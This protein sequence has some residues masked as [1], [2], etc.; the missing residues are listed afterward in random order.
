MQQV[1]RGRSIRSQNR[2]SY[3]KSQ[4]FMSTKPS[5]PYKSMTTIKR[6]RGRPRRQPN[7]SVVIPSFNGPQPEELESDPSAESESDEIMDD[8]KPQY[9]MVAASGLG[10]TDTE[11]VT[12]RD[13]SVELVPSFVNLTSDDDDD[14]SSPR[15]HKRAKTLSE[16][17]PDPIADDSTALL[18]Q[19]QARVYGP[20]DSTK[21]SIIP[22]RSKSSPTLDDSATSAA[23]LRQ[24][25]A[26]T[27]HSSLD[28]SS[29]DSLMGPTQR[30][31]KPLPIRY[32]SPKPLPGGAPVPENPPPRDKPATIPASYLT[33][34]TTVS[35]IQRQAAK[36]TP[37]EQTSPF[38]HIQRKVSL[39]PHFPPS[40]SFNHKYSHG[41]AESRPQ[42][43]IKPTPSQPT[44]SGFSQSSRIIPSS[45]KKRKLSPEPRS[46]PTQSSQTSSRT[47]IGFAGLARAKDITDD[48]APKAPIANPA[49]TKASHSPT[50]QLLGA[51][52]S[53]S[54]D[55]L[56]RV[57]SSDSIISEV[58]VVRR[59]PIT[60]TDPATT[61]EAR[62]QESED[63]GSGDESDDS[64]DGKTYVSKTAVP[65]QS[66]ASPEKVS[67]SADA[68]SQAFEIGHEDDSAS[69][70]DSESDSSEVMIVRRS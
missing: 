33:N 24:F 60:S 13:Q 17:S 68:L 58:I 2:G 20:D 44:N 5:V 47:K 27:R 12:S 16:T 14:E 29:S 70:S 56:A 31:L 6:P 26:H 46:V 11:D 34:N 4:K 3:K 48:F 57:S 7:F 45:P 35:H 59:N 49:P 62:P 39:T 15:P 54:E 41:S 19:F 61:A 37:K 65:V 30:S 23:L 64:A 43:S 10:Q 42:A 38:N 50:A 67:R 1:Q 40:T 32:V 36:A 63:G 21:G 9:S 8:P 25:H 28:S 55:Q 22:A 18:R 53:E 51:E 69:E 52:D 66:A